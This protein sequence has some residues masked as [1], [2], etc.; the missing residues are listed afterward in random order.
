MAFKAPGREKANDW[1]F[2]RNLF[3]PQVNS[4]R[5][6]WFQL[7][8]CRVFALLLRASFCQVLYSLDDIVSI[9]DLDDRWRIGITK[10]HH[11]RAIPHDR[12]EN[13][14]VNRLRNQIITDL[15][16][17]CKIIRIKYGPKRFFQDRFI[18]HISQVETSSDFEGNRV[19][20][21]RI[22]AESDLGFPTQTRLPRCR[23]AARCFFIERGINGACSF[24]GESPTFRLCSFAADHIIGVSP[25]QFNGT[26]AGI[27]ERLGVTTQ[28]V[29]GVTPTGGATSQGLTGLHALKFEN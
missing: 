9:T 19:G 5:S 2:S 26:K 1:Q 21:T 24:G 7:R 17:R 6:I 14:R 13:Y 3:D 18:A 4:Q 15:L 29:D 22:I 16:R 10:N 11:I 25:C 28:R 20:E 27:L 23:L 8:F 12:R